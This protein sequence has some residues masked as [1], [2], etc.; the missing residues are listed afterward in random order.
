M[1][2]RIYPSYLEAAMRG[3][4]DLLTDDIR[5]ALIDL[6]AYTFDENHNMLNDLTGVVASTGTGLTGK[7][8]TDGIFLATDPTIPNVTGSTVEAVVC[9][10]HTG[11]SS[12]SPLICFADRKPDGDPIS[13][14]P[15]GSGVTV[16]IPV[17]GIFDLNR[18]A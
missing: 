7:S 5:F 8:V 11:V 12:T 4:I 18:P 16:N 14:T 1:A 17:E 2:N 6:G 15:N 13:F 10:K 3:E 9:Y